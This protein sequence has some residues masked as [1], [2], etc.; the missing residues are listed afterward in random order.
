MTTAAEFTFTETP[1]E[2]QARIVR[3]LED[4]AP[5]LYPFPGDA[6][7]YVIETYFN[8]D[9]D[10]W[11]FAEQYVKDHP[12]IRDGERRHMAAVAEGYREQATARWQQAGKAATAD[13]PLYDDALILLR[14]A[15]L[16][17]P[18][19]AEFYAKYVRIVEDKRNG[20][21]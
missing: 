19:E 7:R 20:S 17:N 13:P 8:G 1:G 10:D 12:E 6:A 18:A 14:E 16:L 9:R 2:H 5:N 15:F 4:M 11:A 21:Y 3:H